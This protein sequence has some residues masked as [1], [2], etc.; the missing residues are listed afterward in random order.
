MLVTNHITEFTSFCTRT[1]DGEETPDT[2][3]AVKQIHLS[4]ITSPITTTSNERN[5]KW[6]QAKQKKGDGT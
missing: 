3:P 6:K 2:D 1:H 4:D 5:T